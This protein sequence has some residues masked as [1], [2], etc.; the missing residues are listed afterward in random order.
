MMER[1]VAHAAS[2]DLRCVVGTPGASQVETMQGRARVYRASAAF[3]LLTPFDSVVMIGLLA[4]LKRRYHVR[5]LILATSAEGHVGLLARRVLGLPFIMFAHG[6]EI[7]SLRKTEWQRP[8]AAVRSASA[9]LA[10]SRYTAALLYQLGVTPARVRIVHPGCD[11]DRFS[12]N[13]AGAAAQRRQ[14][15]IEPD[16]FMLL[17][18]A[19]VVERKGHDVVLRAVAR[20]RHT[21]P[22]LTYVIAGDGPHAAV[23]KR[24]ASE[25]GVGDCV[26]FL[27]R[28]QAEDLPGLYA[29]SDVFVMPSRLRDSDNDVEGFGIVYVEAS[30]CERP[31]IGGRSGGVEDAIVDGKTGLLV[32]P[33]DVEALAASI[34]RLWR[35]PE[36]RATLGQAGRHRAM[37]ELTWRHFAGRVCAAVREAA[38][39]EQR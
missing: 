34:E 19:N 32:D 11:T 31:V 26:R 36:L 22:R 37:S 12:P 15:G 7:L 23:L 13:A 5:A 8:L 29:A 14:L 25:L 38:G 21:I 18:V 30:A 6:N 33:L 28:I 2:P 35:Y 3:R 10:N 1:L 24:L 4:A 16:C 20:L 9:V 39:V 27:G 17:T